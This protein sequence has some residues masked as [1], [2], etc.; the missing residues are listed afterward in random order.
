MFLYERITNNIAQT[1]DKIRY[2]AKD[3]IKMLI[4]VIPGKIGMFSNNNEITKNTAHSKSS[5]LSALLHTF[6]TVKTMHIS[7]THIA[8]EIYILFSESLKSFSS[9][10]IYDSALKKKLRKTIPCKACRRQMR[11]IKCRKHMLRTKRGHLFFLYPWYVTF[12]RRISKK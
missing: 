5:I 9:I 6:F 7:N 3:I 10:P 1:D 8:S 12:L 11:Q 4:P 2:D